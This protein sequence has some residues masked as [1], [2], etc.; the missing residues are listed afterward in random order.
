MVRFNFSDSMI[1]FFLHPP[2]PDLNQISLSFANPQMTAVGLI[3]ISTYFMF[4]S[5]NSTPEE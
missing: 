2:A 5:F 4:S 1:V 3:K